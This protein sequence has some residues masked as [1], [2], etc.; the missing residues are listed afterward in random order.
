LTVLLIA[1]EHI[2]SFISYAFVC[3]S[4][5]IPNI[6]HKAEL[7]SAFPR[8]EME[9]FDWKSSSVTFLKFAK[10]LSL[11]TYTCHIL[12]GF[13]VSAGGISESLVRS[14]LAIMLYFC[15]RSAGNIKL[16]CARNVVLN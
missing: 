15:A 6:P 5:E 4:P 2:C 14:Y 1:L 13:T 7:Q 12:L 16:N 3:C 9:Y 10:L 11:P 8:D